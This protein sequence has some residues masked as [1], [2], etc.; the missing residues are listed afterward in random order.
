MVTRLC[1]SKPGVAMNCKNRGLFGSFKGS[2]AN[3]K[4]I[5]YLIEKIL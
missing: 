1:Q 2:L 5:E 3:T 4:F